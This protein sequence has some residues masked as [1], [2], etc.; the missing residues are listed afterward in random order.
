MATM[1]YGVIESSNNRTRV[2]ENGVVTTPSEMETPKRLLNIFNS[3][4]ALIQKYSPDAMAYEELFF[5]KNAKTALIVGHARGVAV[6]AGARHGIDLFEYTPLQVKQAVVGYGR[7]D[8]Q[9]VQNMVKLLLNLKEI[10]KP[11][12]AADAGCCH[13]PPAQQFGRRLEV[14]KT[15]K[16]ESTGRERNICTHT[17]LEYWKNW[18]VNVSNRC[19]WDWILCFCSGF[20]FAKAA[21]DRRKNKAFHLYAP[22]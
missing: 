8:K 22:S 5:N 14:D 16:D 9:Q 10:P 18:I 21:F 13:M 7:A 6:L 11:D 2:L 1:G 15:I 12:D 20:N 3:V 19:Q 4:E 17:Y